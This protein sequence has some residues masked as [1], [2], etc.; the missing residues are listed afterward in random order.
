MQSANNEKIVVVVI[1]QLL[2]SLY[3]IYLKLK[4]PFQNNFVTLNLNFTTWFDNIDLP[5][6]KISFGR[7]VENSSMSHED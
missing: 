7:S 1:T 5:I 2:S 6:C 4:L 3:V